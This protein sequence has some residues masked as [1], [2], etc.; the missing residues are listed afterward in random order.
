MTDYT[1]TD[2]YNQFNVLSWQPIETAP[3]D[4]LLLMFVPEQSIYIGE[5]WTDHTSEDNDAFFYVLE[6][7]EIYPTHWMPLPAPPSTT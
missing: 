1:T 5:A 7:G 6:L 2:H 3:R 4:K